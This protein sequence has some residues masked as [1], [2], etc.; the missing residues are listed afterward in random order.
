MAAEGL[1]NLDVLTFTECA[2]NSISIDSFGV[3]TFII[4]ITAVN[5]DEL[6]LHFFEQVLAI[7]NY[8]LGGQNSLMQALIQGLKFNLSIFEW[9][10]CLNI[11]G[12]CRG[13][14]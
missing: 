6:V 9:C 14:N 10:A 5:L 13:G 8:N 11:H 1:E 7:T 2:L 12:K 3:R 4:G